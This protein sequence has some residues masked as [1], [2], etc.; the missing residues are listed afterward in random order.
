M[1]MAMRRAR[2][3]KNSISKKF[4]SNL[5]MVLL[6]DVSHNLVGQTKMHLINS[7][8]TNGDFH[9]F[10]GVADMV[11]LNDATTAPKTRDPHKRWGE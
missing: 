10:W 1:L 4:E 11:A 8:L 7:T 9:R 5:Q 6:N 2:Q 3:L